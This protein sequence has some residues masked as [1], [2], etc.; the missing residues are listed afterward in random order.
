MYQPQLIERTTYDTAENEP[1]KACPLSAYRSPRYIY[2]PDW[3]PAHHDAGA[4][5]VIVTWAEDEKYK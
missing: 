3:A 5:G 2:W 4:P 1:C